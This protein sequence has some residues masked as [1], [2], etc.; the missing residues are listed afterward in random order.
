MPGMSHAT[1]MGCR[2][3]GTWIRIKEF[4]SFLRII[5]MAGSNLKPEKEFVSNMLGMP[6]NT[7][8]IMGLVGG[9]FFSLSSPNRFPSTKTRM[10]FLQ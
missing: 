3:R 5:R 7:I 9:H 6:E 4:T 2:S 1:W 10:A 8:D